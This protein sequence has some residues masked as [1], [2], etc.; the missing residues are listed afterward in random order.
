MCKL[1]G[2]ERIAHRGWEESKYHTEAQR[3][4]RSIIFDFTGGTKKYHA[5]AQR[6]RRIIIFDF[7]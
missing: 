1:T 4:R 5:E 7:A 2:I 3:A 6:A